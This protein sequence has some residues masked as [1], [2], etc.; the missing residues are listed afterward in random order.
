MSDVLNN[1]PLIEV[2]FEIRWNLPIQNNQPS[3]PRFAVFT[4]QL[5]EHIKKRFPHQSNLPAAQIPDFAS[6]HL[7]KVQFRTGPEKW[8]LIQVGA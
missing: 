8:P 1:K 5:Y 6:A 4:G 3:D 7:P 2:I